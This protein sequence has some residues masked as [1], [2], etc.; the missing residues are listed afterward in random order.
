MILICGE[1][2]WVE[3]Y[4]AKAH[5]ERVYDDSNNLIVCDTSQH[6]QVHV[7]PVSTH[8]LI[9]VYIMHPSSQP[10]TRDTSSFT[11]VHVTPPLSVSYGWHL[12]FHINNT[13]HPHPTHTLSSGHMKHNMYYLLMLYFTRTE[14][15]KL[16]FIYS[17]G[18]SSRNIYS[19]AL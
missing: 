16:Y 6:R 15:A 12:L 19:L 18:I 4:S 5:T 8:L 7:T 10:C 2:V 17:F 14:S 9:Y 3:S 1:F 11:L 13:P